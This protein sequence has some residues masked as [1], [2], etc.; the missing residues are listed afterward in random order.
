MSHRY[1]R[2]HVIR[3]SFSSSKLLGS[4]P[5]SDYHELCNLS[6]ST[7]DS[8]LKSD[9]RINPIREIIFDIGSVEIGVLYFVR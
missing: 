1:I 5:Q 4:L 9:I 6:S 3:N 2:Y 7:G 8:Q